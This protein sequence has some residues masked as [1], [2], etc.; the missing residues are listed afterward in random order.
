M[1][2]AFVT[3]LAAAFIACSRQDYAVVSER[4]FPSPDG[5]LVASIVEET[6][7]NTTGYEKQVGLR[8]HGEKRPRF[9]NLGVYGP[10]D[11]VTVEWSSRTGLVVQYTYEASRPGPPPTNIFGVTI[12]FKQSSSP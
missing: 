7:F 11:T 4:D 3:V 5:A 8:H 6:Y 2:F 9:G 12:R 10:G 1:R